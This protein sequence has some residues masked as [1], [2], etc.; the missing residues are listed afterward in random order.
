MAI[1]AHD[2]I[3]TLQRLGI[4]QCAADAVKRVVAAAPPGA[5]NWDMDKGLSSWNCVTVAGA[6][7]NFSVKFGFKFSKRVD[8][9]DF[10]RIFGPKLASLDVSGQ[11][12]LEGG[13]FCAPASL[14]SVPGS[15]FR[16]PVC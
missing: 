9:A 6:G 13:L 10:G 8:L 2:G 4:A 5:L 14:V 11:S 7:A 16:E 1:A 15:F 12:K 3:T